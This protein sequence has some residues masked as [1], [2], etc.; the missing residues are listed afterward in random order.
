MAK[1]GE[2]LTPL[3]RALATQSRKQDISQEQIDVAHAWMQDKIGMTQAATGLDEP[4]SGTV[5]YKIACY[6][7]ESYRRGQLVIK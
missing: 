2:K 6:L 4:R 3:Q 5:L 7:R 1:R